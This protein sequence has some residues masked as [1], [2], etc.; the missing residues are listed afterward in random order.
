LNT[1]LDATQRDYA[2]TVCSSAEALLTVID[3]ILDFSKIEAGKLDVESVTFDLR[4]VVE[5]SAVLLAARAQQDGLELT[6]RIDPALPA[7]LEGDPGR[8]RQVLLNLLGNAVKFTSAGE[9]N[10]TARLAG[11]SMSTVSIGRAVGSRYRHRDDRGEPGASVRRVHPGRQ[12]HLPPLRRHRARS[13]DLAPARRADGWDAERDERT[14]R[15][16][17]VHGC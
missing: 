11:E 1:D 14:R 13:G 8:L 17:H 12:L 9:V 3:D 2:E 4:S 10:L 6:C 7:A 5:E 16:Q 15:R